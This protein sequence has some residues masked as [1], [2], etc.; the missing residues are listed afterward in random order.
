MF[1]YYD[2]LLGFTKGAFG[3]SDILYEMKKNEL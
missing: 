1:M 3:L 2:P